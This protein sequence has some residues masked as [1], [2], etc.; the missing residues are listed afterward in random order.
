MT[1]R[2]ALNGFDF[3]APSSP[4]GGSFR[5]RELDG[6]HSVSFERERTDKMQQAGA[7]PATGFAKAATIT[8]RGRAHYSNREAAALE[9]RELMAV[10]GQEQ[11]RLTVV[12]E[13]GE[14]TRIVEV[15]SISVTPVR[16][17]AF[18]WAFAVTAVDP[19]V[20]GPE[21]YDQT[22][23]SSTA[24]GAGLTYPLAYP[25]NYGVAAG[26]TPGQLALR[27]AGTESYHPR[28]RIT[29]P[30]TRPVVTLAETGDRVAYN[31]TLAAG[32]WLDIDCARRRTLLNGQ[33]SVRND[34]SYIGAWLA[35]PRGGASMAW[36]ADTADPAAALSVWSYE[37]AWS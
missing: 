36:T 16:D 20:Y 11:Y 12:D 5:L 28:L 6:W 14:G 24:A 33:V 27:N 3:T 37:G 22:G 25:L 30:V 17:G 8:A 23:L 2:L 7:W 31:G 9:R 19:L 18:Q 13:A 21:R 26:V 10:A 1:T 29:G 32:Q 15:D 34:V 4:R 35:V